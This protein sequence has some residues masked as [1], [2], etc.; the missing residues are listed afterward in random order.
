MMLMGCLRGIQSREG[1]VHT[2]LGSLLLPIQGIVEE[3]GMMLTT[4]P[5]GNIT[6]NMINTQI[7]SCIG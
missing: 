7:P 3:Q 6:G 5:D 4:K 1:L 2:I